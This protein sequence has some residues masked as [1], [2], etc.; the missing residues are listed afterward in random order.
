MYVCCFLVY[1]LPSN[2]WL[3]DSAVTLCPLLLWC[4]CSRCLAGWLLASCTS[5]WWRSTSWWVWPP[6]PNQGAFRGWIRVGLTLSLRLLLL[7][8]LVLTSLPPIIVLIPLPSTTPAP[9]RATTLPYPELRWWSGSP[10]SPASLFCPLPAPVPWAWLHPLPSWWPLGSVPRT[11]SSSKG[12]SHW[13]LP[14]RSHTN[15]TNI[16][17]FYLRSFFVKKKS[18][19][20]IRFMTTRKVKRKTQKHKTKYQE[21]LIIK[22]IDRA[23]IAPDTNSC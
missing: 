18:C 15:S 17:V 1:R 8:H 10:S 23:I 7:H 11:A 16:C 5:R 4:R 14:T 3:T 22:K 21:N 13:R 2:S 12:G 19:K 20:F 6:S 9:H